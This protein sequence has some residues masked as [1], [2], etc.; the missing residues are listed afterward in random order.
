MAR[1]VNEV[2]IILENI[3][4]NGFEESRG[5]YKITRST[6]RKIFDMG[7]LEGGTLIHLH[8]ELRDD[9]F[10]L[11]PLDEDD[12]SKAKLW[13]VDWMSRLETRPIADYKALERAERRALATAECQQARVGK[14][15][16]AH[17]GLCEAYA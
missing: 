14:A 16:R 6:L 7:R 8:E 3:Y 4:F 17:A 15:K 13:V 12:F 10:L 5:P 2:G 1:S 9:G 11:Y